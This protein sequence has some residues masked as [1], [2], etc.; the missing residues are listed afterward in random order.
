[1][2]TK[3]KTPEILLTDGGV[4][5][6]ITCICGNTFQISIWGMVY[7]RTKKGE[8]IKYRD[9]NDIEPPIKCK[10]G[11]EYIFVAIPDLAYKI[12]NKKKEEKE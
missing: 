4:E 5:A 7:E 11:R 12:L 9:D 10:C 8:I 3:K 1:M 6:D 2:V